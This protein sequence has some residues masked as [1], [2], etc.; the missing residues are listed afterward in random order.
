MKFGKKLS[1]SRLQK[2]GNTSFVN[3]Y[4]ENI[5][6]K[7]FDNWRVLDHDIKMY[8]DPTDPHL[9]YMMDGK[10]PEQKIKE[11]FLEN[12]YS[13]DVVIDVGSN[14]GQMPQIL[15]TPKH[16]FVYGIEIQPDYHADAM[17]SN[18]IECAMRLPPHSLCLPIGHDGAKRTPL[19]GLTVPRGLQ[20]AET[21]S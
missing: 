6:K 15:A 8:V 21:C 18:T 7:G 5:R 16:R 12:I 1:G 4:I 10:D 17:R 14:K 2:L 20:I 11:I 9:L 3:K 19:K 13:G